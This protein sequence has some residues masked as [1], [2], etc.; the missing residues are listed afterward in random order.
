MICVIDP[1]TATIVFAAIGGAV[2]GKKGNSFMDGV[3]A[4]TNTAKLGKEIESL[5][6]S[7]NQQS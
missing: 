1:V 3:N 7:K 6:S 4:A 2:A 5:E